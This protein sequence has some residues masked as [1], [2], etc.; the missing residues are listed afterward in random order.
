VPNLSWLA[1]SYALVYPPIARLRGGLGVIQGLMLG[2]MRVPDF[3]CLDQINVDAS[4]KWGSLDHNQRGLH[5]WER[6][7][8]ER[9]FGGVRRIGLTSVGGGR[10]VIALEQAGYEVEAYECNPILVD[11][12][13]RNLQQ[14]GLM[15]RVKWVERDLAPRFVR[16]VDAV[17]V[18]WGAYT[19]TLGSARR[20][21]FLRAISTQLVQDAPLLLSYASLSNSATQRLDERIHRIASAIRWLTGGP[22][23]EPGDTLDHNARH[24]FTTAEI[25]Q[26]LEQAGFEMAF[27]SNDGFSH[28]VG[29]RSCSL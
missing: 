1:K 7:V 19:M 12:A 6:H 18:G 9:F 13:N 2:L 14:L 4:E 10:E 29:L 24:R 16:P 28:A 5:P 26:E 17:I 15:T 21:D 8:L 20:V 27:C 23:L 11:C 25:R 22:A 3:H